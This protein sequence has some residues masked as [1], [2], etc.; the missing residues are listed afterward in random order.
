MG[1][2]HYLFNLAVSA[3]VTVCNLMPRIRLKN[4]NYVKKVREIKPPVW[5]T[6]RFWLLI[7]SVYAVWIYGLRRPVYQHLYGSPAE[8][9]AE[10]MTETWEDIPHQD[11]QETTVNGYK[12]RYMV[13]KKYSVTG[14]IVYLDWYHFI[15]TWYRSAMNPGV[16]LYDGVVPVDVSVLHGATAAEDNWHKLKFTHEYRLLWSRPKYKNIAY[17]YNPEERNNNHTIPASKNILRAL[18]IVKIGEPVYIEGY[19]VDWEGTGKYADFKIK[20]AVTPGELSH[21]KAGGLKT[22]LCRQ[23]FITKISFGGYT[24]E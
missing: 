16:Y 11:W 18:K 17:V 20:T 6:M 1:F 3:K 4:K 2:E 22:W 15:G 23:I 21:E 24:F 12:I 10:Q 5:Q 14:R 8:P 13:R 7:V 9:P 19:L